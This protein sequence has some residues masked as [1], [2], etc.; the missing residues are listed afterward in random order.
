MNDYEELIKLSPTAEI[1]AAFIKGYRKIHGCEDF[2]EYD[3]I[4]V[5]VSGGWDS[6]IVVDFCERIGYPKGVL[7]YVFFNTG[8]EFEAT[9]KHIKF[10]ENKYQIEIH[11]E[12]AFVPIPLSCRKYGVPF[13]SKQVSEWIS[14]LQKHNFQW[15]NESFEVLYAKYPKC[16]AALRWWC[17]EWGEKSR[18]NI[19]YNKWLKEFLV[20]NPPDFPISNKCCTYA[21]KKT[22]EKVKEKYE[23]DLDIQGVRQSEGGA[24]S[25]AYDSC[26]DKVFGG[27]DK[28]RPI[29][30]FTRNDKTKYD[31]VFNV[32]HSDCYKK[33][34][35]TRTGCACCPFGR[36]FEFELEAAEKY[37]PKLHK[38]ALNIFGKSY[39]YTR[40]YRE[41]YNRMESVRK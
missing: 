18:N 12:K 19:R 13:L 6:D 4:L 22:A 11:E 23:P 10:L 16:K 41:F 2:R 28:Y 9:K 31:E 37:E 25:Q 34:G 33:Y 36:N 35:L 30:W 17:N 24:R 40:K 38:A 15:E 8:V 21:K 14:R 26:F 3:K 32:T 1:Q 27:T 7:T 39:E 29:F 5:S 20:A